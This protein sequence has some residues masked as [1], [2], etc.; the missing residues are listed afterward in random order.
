M[1][2]SREATQRP[3]GVPYVALWSGEQNGPPPGL[4]PM[5]PPRHPRMPASAR[6]FHRRPRPRIHPERRQRRPLP[7][8]HADP[9]R[10]G[11][12]L[13]PLRRRPH[14]M[15]PRP[16]TDRAPHA[17]HA[18]RPGRRGVAAA[19]EPRGA[20]GAFAKTPQRVAPPRPGGSGRAERQ[21]R[22]GRRTAYWDGIAHT[23]AAPVTLGA[24]PERGPGPTVGSI[25]RE[26]YGAG[27]VS[28]AIGFHH[29]DLGVAEVPAP[30]PGRC[31]ACPE[32]APRGV[33][34]GPRREP[35]R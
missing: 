30:A 19:V 26:R 20:L 18:G 21:R 34:P 9:R 1:T 31:G 28:V 2:T 17:L 6:P 10:P 35:R 7:A 14:A 25:L 32:E 12:R 11:G 27:Y 3:N 16:S 29:G 22:T 5:R 15:G 8:G 13:R 33:I 4:P 24:A 23:C